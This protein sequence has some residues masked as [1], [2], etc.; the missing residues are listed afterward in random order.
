MSVIVW[1]RRDLRLSDNPAL[2]DAIARGEP[3]VPVYVLDSDTLIGGASRWWLHGS[4]EALSRDLACLGAPLVL[5]RGP[6][7][8]VIPTLAQEVNARAIVWNRCYEP[9][10]VM[11]DTHLKAAL[12]AKGLDV[13]TFNASLLAEPWEINTQAGE[14]YKVFTPF[15]RALQ[16]HRPLAVPLRSPDAIRTGDAVSS[17]DLASWDLRPPKP[18]WADGLNAVWSPGE[19]SA[20]RRLSDFLNDSAATYEELRDNPARDAT[21]HLSPHLHFGEISP[22]QIWR[23]ADICANASPASARGI[24]AFQRQLGW[25]EFSIHLLYHWPEIANRAWKPEYENFPW[26][27][28]GAHLLAWRRGRTGYPIVDAGMRELWRT[29]IMHNRVRMI[30]AS[31]LVKDLLVDWRRGAEWFE[32]T[33][34]DA[35]LANNRGGWQWVAGSGADASPFFRI[36]NPVTQGEKFDPDGEYVRAHVPELRQLDK[37]FIHKPWEAPAS[38]LAAAGIELGKTYPVPIVAHA[39]ARLRALDALAEMKHHRTER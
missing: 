7:M 14:P 4:L 30:A 32:N 19:R 10:T 6:A 29:G 11:R 22:C 12:S 3:V 18:G 33:L 27:D 9:D 26:K 21:S 13:K 17:D 31:F 15:W 2:A 24:S 37:R 28:D 35:D 5:R 25:R 23:T 8:Q 16:A 34:V 39:A 36:F 1:F 20:A 38:S